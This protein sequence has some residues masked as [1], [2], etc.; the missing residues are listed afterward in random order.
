MVMA[1]FSPS[2]RPPWSSN[3]LKVTPNSLRSMVAVAVN[4]TRCLPQGS[5]RLPRPTARVVLPS[6]MLDSL[7]T[8]AVAVRRAAPPAPTISRA[9]RAP[10]RF[11]AAAALISVGVG[12]GCRGGPDAVLTELTEARRLAADVR[13]QFN[14]GSDASN[15]AV[16]ADTDE[17]SIAFAREV[18]RNKGA[19]EADLV[20]LEPHLRSLAFP[21]E[22]GFLNEFK[23]HFAE[24]EKIDRA[25]LE[26]AVEN[27]NL[28]AQRLS[29]G[30]ARQAADSFR[31]SLEKLG[32]V[33]AADRCRLESAITKAVLAVREIQVLQAPHIAESQDS[34]MTELEKQMDTLQ[35]GARQEVTTLEPLVEVQG[36][37]N[38]AAA[39]AALDRFQEISKE[40][41]KLSRRNSNVRSLELSLR[42]KPAVT[43]A[44]DQDLLSLQ[45][46]LAKEGFA[47]TR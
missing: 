18:D 15:R 7:G 33:R 21:A 34:V 2:A 4:P 19:L 17:A 40:I 32:A 30:P 3:W 38:L 12:A 1:T 9:A 42:Q 10:G 25:I 26:L 11:L 13:F 39:V 43:A 47:A 45:E 27:T 16:M 31:D 20:A 24:Y 22:I 35:A 41:V 23:N 46:A 6:R 28:K 44:A 5:L 37:S 36:R 29:F 8:V 14:K